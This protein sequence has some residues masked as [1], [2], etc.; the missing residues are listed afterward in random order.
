MPEIEVHAPP[1]GQQ[2]HRTGQGRSYTPT[3]TLEAQRLIR[4]TWIEAGF[5]WVADYLPSCAVRVDVMAIFDRPVG[6]FGTGRNTGRLKPSAPGWPVTRT[7]FDLDNLLKL[8]LDALS[9]YAFKDDACVVDARARKRY[10]RDGEVP[11]WR[12]GV[13]PMEGEP[14]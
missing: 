10:C 9:R 11:G 13:F 6:Q 3:S 2:R 1:R 4:E 14:W 12:I 7:T 8:V 5:G